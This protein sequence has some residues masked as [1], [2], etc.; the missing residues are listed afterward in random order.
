MT[1]GPLAAGTDQHVDHESLNQTP[2]VLYTLALTLTPGPSALLIAASGARFGLARCTPHLAGSLFGYE[3]RL[4]AAALGT[5]TVAVR[6]PAVLT[7][8]QLASTAYLLWLGWHMLGSRPATKAALPAPLTWQAAAALQLANPKSWL[9]AIASAG[10]FL[11]ASAPVA[12]QGAFLLYAGAAGVTALAT[13]AAA[14]AALQHWLRLPSSQAA[15]NLA[16]AAASTGTAL[17]RLCGAISE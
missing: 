5:G 4:I 17:W 13:W 1:G 10:L 8:M 15:L 7:P 11:P 9:T 14:G 12:K 16:M 3:M 6:D 2:L